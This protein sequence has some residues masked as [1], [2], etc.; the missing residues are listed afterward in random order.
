MVGAGGVF[1]GL[2]SNLGSRREHI[3][4]ALAEL[5]EHADISVIARSSLHETEPVGGPEGQPLYLNCVA[6]LA[7]DIGP[8][9]LLARLHE[10]EQRHGRRRTVHNGA[11]TLDLDLLLYGEQVVDEPDLRVPHPRMWQRD[12]VMRPLAEV[13][14]PDRLMQLTARYRVAATLDAH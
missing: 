4:G 11:R 5:S 2:G 1:I 13:C 9:K 6:E 14:T 8:R 7:T 3:L 12:F 10:V